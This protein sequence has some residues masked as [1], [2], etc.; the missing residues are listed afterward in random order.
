MSVFDDEVLAPV[1]RAREGKVLQIPVHLDRVKDVVSIKQKIYT[2]LGGGSGSGKTSLVDDMYVL[3]PYELWRNSLKEESD[4]TYKVLYRSMERSR[5]LKL[6]KWTCWKLYQDYKVLI[7]SETLL[8]YKKPSISDQAWEAVVK[9]RDWADEMLDYVDIRDG[10]TTPDQYNTW[11]TGHALRSGTLFISDTVGVFKAGED[12]YI[13]KFSVDKFITLRT[14]DKELIVTFNYSGKDYHLKQGEKKYFPLKPNEITIVI[15]DHVGKFSA[16]KGLGT[17]KDIIDKASEYNADFRDVFGYSPVALSQF[18]RGVGGIDRIKYSGADLSPQI[19]D[20]KDTGSL[21]EDADLVLT[22]FNPWRYSAFDEKG[23]YKGYNIRDGMVNMQGENRYRQL[24][25]LK[26]S[27]GIDDVDYGLR[28]WGEVN[29][30][31]TLPKPED[32][33]LQQVYTDIANGY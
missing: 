31:E 22:I 17:K 29:N 30:F 7:D 20:F 32:P 18:N 5:S 12:V 16:Q 33:R 3:K 24:S 9:C 8:G 23:I 26:N 6:A 10:R 4:I 15:A 14:G 28:F 25:V 27:Y 13:D 2:A 1:L 19:E 21:I 11:V